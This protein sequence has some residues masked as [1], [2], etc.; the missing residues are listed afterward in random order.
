MCICDVIAKVREAER[1]AIVQDLNDLYQAC[2]L[3]GPEWLGGIEVARDVV[4][5][6]QL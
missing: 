3:A 5:D 6:K 1:A 4:K 2:L